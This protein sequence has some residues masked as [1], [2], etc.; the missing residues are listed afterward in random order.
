MPIAPTSR[1]IATCLVLLVLP[2]SQRRPARWKRQSPAKIERREKKGPNCFE[3][4]LLLIGT[5]APRLSSRPSRVKNRVFYF[6]RV[7][8]RVCRRSLSI[9]TVYARGSIPGTSRSGSELFLIS[10]A[11]PPPSATRRVFIKF[12]R[13]MRAEYICISPSIYHNRAV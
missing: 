12:L 9:Y 6:T 1:T 5:P 11:L 2:T 7:V 10:L 3:T 4:V 13:S 8:G